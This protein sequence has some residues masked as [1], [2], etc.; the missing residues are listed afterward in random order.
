MLAG[1]PCDQKWGSQKSYIP[2]PANVLTSPL[3]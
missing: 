3:H 2:R 1:S